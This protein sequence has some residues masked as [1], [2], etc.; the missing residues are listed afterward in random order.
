MTSKHA[1]F[2]TLLGYLVA[3]VRPSEMPELVRLRLIS[4]LLSLMVERPARRSTHW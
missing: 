1:F 2:A 4:G 3:D